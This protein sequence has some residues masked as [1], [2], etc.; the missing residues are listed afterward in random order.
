M[1]ED[2]TFAGSQIKRMRDAQLEKGD[3]TIV[4]ESLDRLQLKTGKSPA[5]VVFITEDLLFEVDSPKEAP[6]VNLDSAEEGIDELWAV[7]S[8]VP[9]LF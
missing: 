2:M 9:G 5:R 6:E 4:N 3:L 8:T 1:I 7:T